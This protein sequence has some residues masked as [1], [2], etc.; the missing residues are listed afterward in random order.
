[1][2]QLAE[3]RKEAL[4]FISHD[5]RSPLASAIQQLQSAPVCRSAQ[6]LPSLRRA[7]AMAQDFLQLA[8]AESLEP[9]QLRPTELAGILH[10]AADQVY[11]LTRERRQQ[12]LRQALDEPLW[13]T[14]NFDL[15]E[16]CAVNLLG[17][18]TKYAPA[19]STIRVGL[20]RAAASVRFWV[21]NV[22][23]APPPDERE[24]LFERFKQGANAQATG[25]GSSTGLG[26]Y[27]VR[28]VAERHGGRA[29]VDAQDGLVRFWVELPAEAGVQG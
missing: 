24:R 25:D 3:Q 10:Q 2:Q 12:L 21:E 7:Q 6:L 18:A 14:G 8:R 29:G 4:T 13:V 28:T 22:G 23:E 17:N 5:L 1:M 16:R 11:P 27:F 20:T 15:L 19:G 9:Q 26:L